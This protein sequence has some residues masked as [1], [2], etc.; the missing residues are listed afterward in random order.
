MGEAAHPAQQSR[1]RARAWFKIDPAVSVALRDTGALPRHDDVLHIAALVARAVPLRC[2]LRRRAN[3][4]ARSFD[5]AWLRAPGST[6][7][8]TRFT[9][10]RAALSSGHAQ[11]APHAQCHRPARQR[12]RQPAFKKK[13]F[14]HIFTARRV[15]FAAAPVAAPA[16]RSPV[17][18]PSQRA[19]APRSSSLTRAFASS[20]PRGC[21]GSKR[22]AR[23]ARRTGA[24]PARPQ[25]LR[26]RLGGVVAAARARASDG[27][28]FLAIVSMARNV[29]GMAN[30]LAESRRCST[31]ALPWCVPFCSARPQLRVPSTPRTQS[32]R[33]CMSAGDGSL[34][35]YVLCRAD[36]N[37]H[38]RA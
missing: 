20:L 5:G 27:T 32:P 30:H 13:R 21:Q 10:A 12:Q 2:P 34:R 11:R 24:G 35:Y 15:E 9:Q 8:R 18:P 25:L 1:R 31:C 4:A 26:L 23:A 19:R 7:T 37:V 33:E 17:A 14:K 22:P 3:R 38:T 28:L 29:R 16:S 36:Y 6:A